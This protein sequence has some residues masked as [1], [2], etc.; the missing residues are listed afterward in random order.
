MN[1]DGIL[2]TVVFS[3]IFTFVLILPLT[4]VNVLTKDLVEQNVRVGGALSVLQSLGVPA[5]KAQPEAVLASYDA[6]KKFKKVD[7]KLVPVSN[8]EVEAAR[9][10]KSPIQPL[11]F[12]GS[13]ASGVTWGGAFTGPGL[14]G[15]V[16]LALG[17]DA[18]IGRIVGYSPVAQVETPGLGARIADQWFIDQF[19]GQKI[20]ASGT[21]RFVAGSG[22]G[23]PNKENDTLDGVTGATITTVAVKNILN[24]AVAEMKSLTG[25][26]Q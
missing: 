16:T 25:G 20:P 6:L 26:V 21:F 23:D 3:L 17:F 4:V 8:E 18:T 14:W 12:Q 13:D 10:A 19:T 9:K 7:G 5:D 2:Y 24:A 1:K 15:N 22:A 11:Y